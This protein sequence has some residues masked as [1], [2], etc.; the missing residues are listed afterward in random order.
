MS[1][2][3]PLLWCSA[4]IVLGTLTLAVTTCRKAEDAVGE[5]FVTVPLDE[6]LAVAGQQG[7]VVFVDFG[8]TWC[9]PCKKLAATTL[10]D[11][12][13]RDWLR[14]HTVPL[15]LDIDEVPALAKEFNVGSVPAMLFLRPDR[16]VLGRIIGYRDV[17]EFLAEAPQRLQGITAAD[18]AR[19]AAALA[20]RDSSKQMDLLRE[21][22][23]EGKFDEALVAAEAYWTASRRDPAQ[24]GVRASFFLTEMERLADKYAPASERMQL[25]LADAKQR[26]EGSNPDLAAAMELASL[27]NQLG[28]TDI[29]LDV[30]AALE[31]RGTD[32]RMAAYA[33][34]A[35]ASKELVAARR[36]AFVVDAGA[37]APQ[38]VRMQLAAMKG[39]LGGLPG[40]PDEQ[41]SELT[42]MMHK[43]A[44][45][46]A[47]PAFEAL[48]GVGNI[49]DAEEVAEAILGVSGGTEVRERLAAAARRAGNEELAKRFAG[50][51]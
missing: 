21:L 39:G 7:K 50:P 46:R 28:Q 30:A 43:T 6:A 36:Y 5:P 34:A 31:R 1:V 29:L 45:E 12:R 11:G 32:G 4:C 37:C 15:R 41:R 17:N 19:A 20:P 26:L 51:R 2:R 23:S 24:A 38:T 48:A 9:G 22:T 35:V 18:Q 42:Q 8:A 49:D 33:L 40:I 27:S 16:S 13:V 47:M 25:W 44:I 14:D 10:A 3:Q